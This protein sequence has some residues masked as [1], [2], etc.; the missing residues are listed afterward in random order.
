MRGWEA[1]IVCKEKTMMITPITRLL[2]LAAL[3]SVLLAGVITA[4]QE[5]SGLS[6]ASLNDIKISFKMDP[7]VTRGMYMGD[8]WISPPTYIM[9]GEGQVCTV[10]ARAEVLNAEGKPMDINLS[11][12]PTDPEMVTVAPAS[13]KEVK[14]TVK[15][16]G[17]SIL[18][19]AS[20]GGSKELAIVATNQGD[21]LRVDIS[22]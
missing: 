21:A 20:P 11:W 17:E 1:R 14:I 16:A 12:T 19:V 3:M 2:A 9:V 15:R 7:R 18:K 6:G 8:R 4:S 10:E 13:G 5:A 22:Q